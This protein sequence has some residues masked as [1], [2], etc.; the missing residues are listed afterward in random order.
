MAA[1]EK[2]NKKPKDVSNHIPRHALGQS[3]SLVRP[4]NDGPR[5]AGQEKP[6]VVVKQMS[7]PEVRIYGQTTPKKVNLGI[8]A[9]D[10]ITRWAG[11]W[12]FIIGFLVLISVWMLINLYAIF[13]VWD[14]YPFI[15]LNLVLSCLAAIQAPVILMSQNRANDRDRVKA[16]RDYAI[17]RKAERETEIIMKDLDHIKKKLAEMN[18]RLK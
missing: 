11:S 5:M 13:T 4:Q 8:K 9:A 10:R 7:V 1:Q 12:Y 6:K 14:P 2:N 15:L 16:E 3:T 18:I 17:N